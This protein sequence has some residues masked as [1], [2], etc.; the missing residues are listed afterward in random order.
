MMQP[1]TSKSDIQ[2]A[3]FSRLNQSLYLTTFV[4]GG[5]GWSCSHCLLSDHATQEECALHPL[6]MVIVSGKGRKQRR[7]QERW[8]VRGL[9]RRP[10]MHGTMEVAGCPNVALSVYAPGVLESTGRTHAGSALMREAGAAG[11]LLRG[12]SEDIGCL[13]I[14]CI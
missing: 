9:Q 11:E 10:A 13:I 7:Q 8:R 5:K 12:G 6:R 2:E 1:S 4:D 14:Q 3:D